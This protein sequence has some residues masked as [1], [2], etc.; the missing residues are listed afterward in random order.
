MAARYPDDPDHLLFAERRR[1][2]NSMINR[3]DRL[4]Y[5]SRGVK[6]PKYSLLN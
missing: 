6:Q 1:K 2:W 4:F 5:E 3:L